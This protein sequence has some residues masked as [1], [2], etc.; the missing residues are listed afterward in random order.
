[1]PVATS[2]TVS[3]SRAPEFYGFVAW[4]STSLLFIV[5]V[6]W[7]LLPDSWI[8]AT[9]VDWYPNRYAPLRATTH[10]TDT[11]FVVLP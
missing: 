8:V 5:Y 3:K 6:L 4:A 9:G 11:T 10:Q 2:Q 1:M 7:A